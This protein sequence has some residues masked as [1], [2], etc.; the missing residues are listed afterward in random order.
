M[1]KEKARVTNNFTTEISI[2][3]L[4]V[5]NIKDKA[6]AS[7]EDKL[8]ILY[9]IQMIDSEIDRINIM[10]GELPL[11]VEDIE[12]EIVGLTTR[13]EKNNAEVQELENQVNLKKNKIKESKALIKKYET[14]LQN[15]RNNREYESLTKEIEYQNLDI[16]YEEKKINEFK[17]MIDSKNE[18]IQSAEKELADKKEEVNNKKKELNEITSENIDKMN[19]LSDM[20]IDYQKLLDERLLS[21]YIKI[22]KNAKNGLSIVKIQRDSCGGCFNKIPPQRQLEIK[23]HKKIIVCEYCGRILIDDSI[24]EKLNSIEN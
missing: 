22:R 14:Q 7:I 9:S 17:L 19:K 13:I 10:K 23:M 15:V 2:P 18:A 1:L 16:K 12:D 8:L 21:A 20:S 11:E 24:S 5:F 3:H 6:N 4:P